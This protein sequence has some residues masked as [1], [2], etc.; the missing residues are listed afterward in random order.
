MWLTL[1]G[2]KSVVLWIELKLDGFAA[3]ITR[4]ILLESAVVMKLEG[5]GSSFGGKHFRAPFV[6]SI[7]VGRGGGGSPDCDLATNCCNRLEQ[8]PTDGHALTL[9]AEEVLIGNGGW[10]D[11]RNALLDSPVVVLLAGDP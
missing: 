2:A 6:G 4:L 1:T 11:V 5:K 10:P 9:E 8:Y 7:R 3:S